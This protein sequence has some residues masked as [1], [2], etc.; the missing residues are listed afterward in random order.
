MLICDISEQDSVRAIGSNADATHAGSKHIAGY[1]LAEALWPGRH[2]IAA[3]LVTPTCE[4][5]EFW[6]RVDSG[7]EDDSESEVR[8]HQA[9]I[10]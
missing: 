10:K 9:S 1:A 6:R 3:G 4:R 7:E 5:L 2:L 8:S